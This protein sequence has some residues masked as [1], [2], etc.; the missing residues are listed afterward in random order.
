MKK[1]QLAI[2]N[3]LSNFYFIHTQH[4]VNNPYTHNAQHAARNEWEK[5]KQ[6]GCPCLN[7]E[8]CA[9]CGRRDEWNGGNFQNRKQADSTSRV[10]HCIFSCFSLSLYSFFVIVYCFFVFNFIETAYT[11]PAAIETAAEAIVNVVWSR[12]KQ[13]QRRQHQLLLLLFYVFLLLANQRKAKEQ[14]IVFHV[15]VL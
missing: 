1:K 11:P 15:I 7:G 14:M 10:A 3:E 12:S 6:H 13:Q 5:Q 9:S 8:A 2:P 4:E